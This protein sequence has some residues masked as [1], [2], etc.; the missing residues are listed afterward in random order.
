[1]SSG[2]IVLAIVL[3]V[4]VPAFA[5]GLRAALRH[6]RRYNESLPTN[7][8]TARAPVQ[9]TPDQ[10]L[11][12]AARTAAE[13]YVFDPAL[14][15]DVSEAMLNERPEAWHGKTIR[16]T[17]TWS[18]QFE[19]SFIGPAFVLA[20]TDAARLARGRHRV[21]ATGLWVFPRAPRSTSGMPGFGHLGMSWGEF[22]VHELE[23]LGAADDAP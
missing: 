6:Q 22:R 3:V 15:V 9:P 18:H 11:V 1:M 8:S 4:V 2:L 17:A 23:Y 20:R 7:T 16:V 21:R 14:A 5:L 19:A 13:A 10:A 12:S